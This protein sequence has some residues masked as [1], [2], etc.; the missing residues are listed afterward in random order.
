MLWSVALLVPLSLAFGAGCSRAG[1]LCALACDCAHCNDNMEDALCAQAEL[2]QDMASTYDC[3]SAWE[4]WAD[5]YEN[6]GH[7]DE[8]RDAYTTTT[9]NTDACEGP[10]TVLADCERAAADINVDPFPSLIGGE[11]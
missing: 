10:A 2:S 1:D 11:G 8:S 4:A 3:D 9:D 5:C 6:Q 7:C